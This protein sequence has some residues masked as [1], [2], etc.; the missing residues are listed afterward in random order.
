VE[1]IEVFLPCKPLDIEDSMSEGANRCSIGRFTTGDLPFHFSPKSS[2]PL[3]VEG[4]KRSFVA[5]VTVGALEGEGAL[6]TACE[7]A[8]SV[9]IGGRMPIGPTSGMGG[10]GGA[11]VGESPLGD[12]RDFVRTLRVGGDCGCVML[13]NEPNDPEPPKLNLLEKLPLL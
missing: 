8:G 9:T 1:S 11:S 12:D 5:G 4:V 7:R 2:A 10:G 6:S 3:K 13:F